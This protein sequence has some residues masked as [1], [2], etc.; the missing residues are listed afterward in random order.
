MVFLNLCKNIYI[1]RHSKY[2]SYSW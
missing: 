1:Y 2:Q